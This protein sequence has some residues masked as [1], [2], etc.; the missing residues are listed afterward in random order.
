M[1]IALIG[2]RG[3]PARYGGFETCAE[4]LGRRLAARGHDVR[5]YCRDS[6]DQPRL[7]TYLGMSL[8]HLPAIRTRSL[9]TLSHVFLA[10]LHALVR[11]NDIILVFNYASSPLLAIPSWLGRRIVLHMD[12]MEWARQKWAGLGHL[13][14]ALAEKLAVTLPIPLIS[15]ARAIQSYYRERHGRETVFLSYGAPLLSSRRPEILDRLGLKPRGYFLQMARFEPENNIHLTLRAFEE[16]ETDK[17]LVLIGGSAYKSRY[18]EILD[19]SRDPR[20]RRLGFCYDQDTLRELLCHSYAYIHGNEAGGTNPGLL[21]ALAAGSF[22][23]ARDVVFNR[24]VA[25]D[26]ALYYPKT[27]AGLRAEMAWAVDHPRDLEAG[28]ERARAIIRS[29]YNWDRVT[30]GYEELFRS[31]QKRGVRGRVSG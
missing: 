2:T 29:R 28:R 23:I 24:E 12:G 26:A 22:V 21:Q 15:D 10:M 8:I 31:L 30:D 17:V 14:F 9:E 11:K 7:S 13:Y 20:V 25:S 16:L 3:V 19:S 1:R 5:V 4:E 27:A 18:M 6:P